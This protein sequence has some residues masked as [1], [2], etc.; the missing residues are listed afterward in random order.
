MWRS[1]VKEVLFFVL[2]SITVYVSSGQ[3]TVNINSGDPAF[4]FPQFLEY[5]EGKT[6]A[7]FNADGVTHADMEKTMREGYQI[8]ANRFYYTGDAV[9]GIPY[10]RGNDGCPYDCA[11][12][13]TA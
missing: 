3:V 5:Q 2:L 4:P 6:F 13:P 9:D 10:I 1:F 11:E 12:G 8:M 7:L